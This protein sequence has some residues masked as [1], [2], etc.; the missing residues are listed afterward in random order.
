MC[1]IYVDRAA[2]VAR[3]EAIVVNAKCQRPG[4]CNA[5]ETLLIHKDMANKFLPRL[6]DQFKKKGVEI[7]GDE[8]VLSV[9]S[10]AKLAKEEDWHTEFLDLVMAVRVVD[11]LEEA[12]AH[13]NT[14]GSH[15]SEAIV[16]EDKEAAEQ[17]L[18][19]VDSAAVYHNAST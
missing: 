5:A 13:I 15:H 7:R 4:V 12:I 9:I 3:A 16:T 6:A 18:I 8:N 19:E 2:D 10:W 14:F 1:S 11:S 17:F